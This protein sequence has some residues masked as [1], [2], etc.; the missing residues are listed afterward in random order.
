MAESRC[1]LSLKEK[2]KFGLIAIGVTGTIVTG[3]FVGTLPFLTP[4]LRQIC[5][6]FV[7]ATACQVANI[8]RLCQGRQAGN[9]VDLGSGD[10][11]V[12]SNLAETYIAEIDIRTI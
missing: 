3:L 8:M 2:S 6:P 4:A 7:P 1:S 9:L 5:I 12:V 11:R 10:G